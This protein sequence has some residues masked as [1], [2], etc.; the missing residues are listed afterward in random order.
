MSFSRETTSRKPC[1]RN[2]AFSSVSSLLQKGRWSAVLFGAACTPG[3]CGATRFFL[4][5]FVSLL[6]GECKQEGVLKITC[7]SGET[8]VLNKHYATKQIWYAS[9]LR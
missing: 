5:F 1:F 4:D 9:P 8:I 7:E 6:S 3:G 2:R